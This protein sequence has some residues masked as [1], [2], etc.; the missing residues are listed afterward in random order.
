MKK[1][2]TSEVLKILH[3]GFLSSLKIK[4]SEEV[5]CYQEAFGCLSM[6]VTSAI[7]ILLEAEK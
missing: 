1:S 6:A 3:T 2:I 4:D 7:E 5:G